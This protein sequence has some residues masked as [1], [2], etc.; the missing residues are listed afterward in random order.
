MHS[1]PGSILKVIEGAEVYSP[2]PLGKMN[3][4][5]ADGR[6]AR[7]Q[8]EPLVLGKLQVERLDARGRLLLPGF[9]DAH[10][11]LL[12][13]GG[14]AG[15]A[16]R[17]PELV[18]SDLTLGGVTTVVGLLGTDATTRSLPSLLAKARG[19]EAEGVTAYI[20]TGSYQVPVRTF[21]GSVQDDLI[22]IDK[23]VGV[24]ELAVSD[25]RSA[26]P[27]YEEFCRI[28]AGA[29]VG[30]MLSGKPG[31]VNV[32]MGGGDRL[33]ALVERAV[34]ETEIPAKHFVP[35]HINRNQRLLDAGAAYARQDGSKGR[36]LDLT[37]SHIPQGPNQSCAAAFHGLLQAGVPIGCISFSSDGQGSLPSFNAAG[38]CVGMGVGRVDTLFAEVRSAVQAFGIPLEDALQTITATPAAYLDLRAK[39]TLRE[40]ADADLVLVDAGLEI[41][42]V[43]ARGKVMVREG[44]LR[45]FGTFERDSMAAMARKGRHLPEGFLD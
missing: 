13:G 5:I 27:T 34:A 21:T 19:L 11:H 15:P 3:V 44:V 36:W 12:G 43:L 17:I 37:T 24:G 20:Y 40:G 9:I 31:V 18:L 7:I 26:Q 23:V 4:L 38:Q 22:L 28:A 32:H 25:H 8:R 42:T 6:I 10:V 1:E 16:S 39:G 33:L 2:A 29:R 41:E 35:T 45:S 30:G 14:E